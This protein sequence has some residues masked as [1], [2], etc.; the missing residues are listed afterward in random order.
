MPHFV[1]LDESG[2]ELDE[3]QPPLESD[4]SFDDES[5]PPPWSDESDESL[6]PS[7]PPDE[8]S[9]ESSVEPSHPSELDE[10]VE[11]E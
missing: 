5:Q 3:S 8:S 2:L 7:H 11:S 1:S 10:S 4:E 6:E 9:V